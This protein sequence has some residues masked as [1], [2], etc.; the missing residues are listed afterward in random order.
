MDN[1]YYQVIGYLM[2]LSDN[3]MFHLLFFFKQSILS[4]VTSPNIHFDGGSLIDL[5]NCVIKIIII[6]FEKY[7]FD[8]ILF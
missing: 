5:W 7:N 6:N 1:K 4:S 3:N 8:I 2:V